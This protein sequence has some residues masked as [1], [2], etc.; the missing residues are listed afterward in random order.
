[1]KNVTITAVVESVQV[2][3]F[4]SNVQPSI[5]RGIGFGKGNVLT[6]RLVETPANVCTPTFLA[7]AAKYLATLFPDVLRC[8]ILER[9]DCVKLGMGS[10]LA[11]SECAA[12]PPKFIHLKYAPP[13]A[14]SDI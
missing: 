4:K 11:V 1:M 2:N 5:N 8:N 10:Y 13:N 6:K 9:E 3:L 7:D 12:E 14:A